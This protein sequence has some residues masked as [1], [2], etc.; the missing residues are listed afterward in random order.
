VADARPG[1]I[2]R[3]EWA[4]AAGLAL[5]VMALTT[6][7]YLAAASHNSEAWSFGGSLVGV[8]DGNAYIAKMMRGATGSWLYTIPYTSEPQSGVFLHIFYLLL[9][10][11]AGPHHTALVITFH[12]ARIICGFA[13][14]LCS[15]YFLA[16]FLPEMRQRRLG[17]LLVALGGGLGWLITLLSPKAL[18]NSLPVDFISPEAFS[19]LILFGLP[20][21]AAARSLMLLGLVAFLRG[22]GL[23]A[24][25]ALVGVGLFQPLAVGVAWAVVGTFLL[26]SAW[27]QRLGPEWRRDLRSAVVLGVLSAP[28]LLYT[29]SIMTTNPLLAKWNSQSPLPS[30][31]PVHYVLAYGV[32]LALAAAGWAVLRRT[33]PRQA[34]FAAGWILILPVLLYLPINPQ[35]R[36]A[37]GV[38]LP[39]AALAVTG[40]T[41]AL[42]RWQKW[43]TPVALLLTLPTAVLLWLGALAV[44]QAPSE[45]IFHPTDELAAFAWLAEHGHTGEVALS[46]QSTGNALPAY[47]PLVPFIGHG[48][49]TLDLERKA[50]LVAAFYQGATHSVER[51]A[52]LGGE[53]IRYV[54]FGPHERALGDFDPALVPYLTQRFAQGEYAVYEVTP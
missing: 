27:R 44:A 16:E 10:H 30:P 52:L 28:L 26:L 11:L 46:A 43:L 6:A 53:R 1:L 24:G 41:M 33:S 45:P 17:L 48:P 31:N 29:V 38:Q 23:R 8:D 3:R 12:I 34:L 39:L 15:Y 13:L 40:L 2:S 9:G 35:R 5:I 51:R 19:F 50:A 14:L 25:L 37:E 20:H 18:F 22:H 36:L 42:R 4:W 7:P 49:E 47:T 54:I 32:W 21:L